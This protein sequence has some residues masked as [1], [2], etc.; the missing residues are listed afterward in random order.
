MAEVLA[1]SFEQ[2]LLHGL[3]KSYITVV[4][5]ETN[6]RLMRVLSAIKVLVLALTISKK[7]RIN[8]LHAT[9][10]AMRRRSP[11]VPRRV[12]LVQ[13]I[14]AD[15]PGCALLLD[16]SQQSPTHAAYCTVRKI[17][18]LQEPGVVVINIYRANLLVVGR[19]QNS[20]KPVQ[21][22]LTG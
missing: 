17:F 22:T 3:V 1:R 4:A 11:G 21:K 18:H 9:K 20:P 12:R 19:Q 2:D 13:H 16:V 8:V 6:P 14:T 7:S 10:T 15:A 5:Q